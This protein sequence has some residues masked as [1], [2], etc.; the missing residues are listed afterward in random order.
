MFASG[1]DYV[2]SITNVKIEEGIFPTTYVKET[3]ETTLRKCQRRYEKTYNYKIYAGL[4]FLVRHI[5]V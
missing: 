5:Q 4:R 3:F 1:G 2:F